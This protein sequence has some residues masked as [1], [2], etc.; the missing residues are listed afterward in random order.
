MHLQ[1]ISEITGILLG[2]SGIQNLRNL[3]DKIHLIGDHCKSAQGGLI[4]AKMVY[5]NVYALCR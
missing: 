4:S 2:E 3:G 1:I 5:R